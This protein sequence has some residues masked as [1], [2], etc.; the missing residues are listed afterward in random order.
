[1]K[2][3]VIRQL[4]QKEK[5]DVLCIEESKMTKLDSKVCREMLGDREM[6]WREVETINYTKCEWSTN[7]F[8]GKRISK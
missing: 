1:M 7:F 2:K 3:K 5:V 6:K 8:G 4:I